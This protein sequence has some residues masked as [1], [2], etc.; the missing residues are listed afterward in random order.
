M[1]TVSLPLRRRPITIRYPCPPSRNHVH[2]ALLSAF[3]PAFLVQ[4]MSNS[5]GDAQKLRTV[6]LMLNTRIPYAFKAYPGIE[7]LRTRTMKFAK[8]AES[9]SPRSLSPKNHSE[10]NRCGLLVHV[11]FGSNA[12]RHP[13]LSAAQEIC[14]IP[15]EQLVEEEK[16]G[17]GERWGEY[18]V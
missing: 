2:L 4:K 17:K 8:M 6:M 11:L 10:M 13:G 3:A 14:L 18:R 15:G 12:I 5:G 7:P 16:R 9:A 1:A